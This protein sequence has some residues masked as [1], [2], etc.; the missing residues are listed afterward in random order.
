MTMYAVIETGGRQVRVQVGETV[1]VERLPADV[2]ASVVFDR[3]LL[4]G[5]DQALKLG[6]PTLD[7][8]QVRATVVRQGRDKKV[9]IHTFK[10]RQNANRKTLGHRQSYTQVKIDAIDL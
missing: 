2:G 7:G 8:V 1:Q 3:V 5:G 9:R 10:H 4:V 6:A